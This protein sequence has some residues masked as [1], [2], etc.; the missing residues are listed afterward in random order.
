M[1]GTVTGAVYAAINVT[2]LNTAINQWKLGE[3]VS[4]QITDRN[5][6]LVASHPD[7]RSVGHPISDDLKPFLSAVGP[8]ATEVKDAGGA[9]ACMDTRPSTTTTC[10]TALPCSSDATRDLSSP[11]SIARSG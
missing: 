1:P 5:G 7:P 9:S 3:N 4:I 11:I 10:G 6:I 2:W 8:G